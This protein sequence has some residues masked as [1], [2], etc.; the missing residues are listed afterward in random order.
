M[1]KSTIAA[2]LALGAFGIG[3][4]TLEARAADP[5]YCDRYARS[6][7]AQFERNR[8]IPGCF[9]GANARWS[10]NFDSHFGWCVR[11]PAGAAEEEKAVRTGRLRECMFAAYGRY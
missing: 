8:S 3:M 6:A 1:L 5:G 4:L 2:T 9:H 10:P 11:V 7:V